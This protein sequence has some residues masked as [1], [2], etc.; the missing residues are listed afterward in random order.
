MTK[1]SHRTTTTTTTTSAKKYPCQALVPRT[2][3]DKRILLWL[4][5]SNNTNTTLVSKVD[6]TSGKETESAKRIK[7]ERAGGKTPKAAARNEREEAEPLSLE[8]QLAI[9]RIKAAG[10]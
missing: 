4:F 3:N 8:K 5:F 7:A 10:D 9:E 2:D 1:P 6:S